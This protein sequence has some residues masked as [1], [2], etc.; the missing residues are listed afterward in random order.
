MRPLGF[1][2]GVR[3]PDGEI[4]EVRPSVVILDLD[5]LG[6]AGARRWAVQAAEIRVL[7]F[8]SHIDRD[9]GDAAAGLGVQIFRRG[10][11]WKELTEV[12]RS[13]AT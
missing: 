12:L 3:R 10:R 1:E 13:P 2:V 7:G 8:Y 5:Q 4:G 6:A 9:L 11:F